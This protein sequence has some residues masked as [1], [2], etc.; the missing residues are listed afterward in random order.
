MSLKLHTPASVPVMTTADAKLHLRVDHSE[1]DALIDSMVSAAT[2]DAEHL[3][4]RA[5]MPQKWLVSLDQ[6]PV[7]C[8]TRIGAR[9]FAI[10]LPMPPVTAIDSVTYIDSAGATTVLASTEYQ[11]SNTD[12]SRNCVVPAYGKS[13]PS[14]RYQ[15]DAVQV[16]FSTGYANAAA[17]PAPIKAWIALRLGALYENRAAW[18][19]GTQ[20]AINRNEF[21]DYLLD[22]YRTF[23]L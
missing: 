10:Y 4:R 8:Q 16:V 11:L 23:T 20:G 7:G 3:M 13:W 19:Q 6:F 2:K 14:A 12:D 1:E 17:V 5:V 9:L 18:T 21:T 22:G 15:A